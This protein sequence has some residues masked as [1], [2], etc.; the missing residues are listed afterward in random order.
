MAT[1]GPVTGP[2]VRVQRY[3]AFSPSP[4]GGNPAGVVLSADGIDEQTMQQIAAEVGYS[5]TAFLSRREAEPGQAMR[6]RY[7]SPEAEV[8]FCGHATIATGVALGDAGSEGRFELMTNVG[9]VVLTVTRSREESGLFTAAFESPPAGAE[10]L[11]EEQLD[12]LLDA[13]GWAREDLDAHF[14]PMVATA[15]NR[16]P[17]LVAAELGR[18]AELNYDFRALAALCR[19]TS[20]T[21]VQLVVPL[22]DRRWRSRSPFP[23]GGVVEDPATGAAAAAF[24]GYLRE[25]GR[26]RPGDQ[27][28]LEQGV[29]M[30]RTSLIAITIGRSTVM[31]TGTATAITAGPAEGGAS[32]Q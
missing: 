7:F 12:R 28:V 16:H 31:V 9:P 11:P 13:L 24:G 27:L 4:N 23:I 1:L 22:T 32:P 18:L 2:P 6:V 14:P 29:E 21:T 3:A 25:L 26:A 15:G 30:G 10:P 20:W 8:D 19:E 5:E 17:V